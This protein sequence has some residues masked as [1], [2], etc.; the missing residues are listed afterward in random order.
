[1]RNEN[2][3]ANT[4]PCYFFSSFRYDASC[5]VSK[6]F[7]RFGNAVP[8]GD[9][10]SADAACHDFQQEFVFANFW[11]R[12]VYYA[13]VFVVVVDGCEQR[14]FTWKRKFEEVRLFLL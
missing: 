6:D 9:I 10:A 5:F 8:F 7:R 3:V 4:I 14:G 12:H 1:M 13:Y 11:R 2:S